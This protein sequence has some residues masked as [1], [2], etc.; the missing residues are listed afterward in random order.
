MPE[1][2]NKNS[3][4]QR[5]I[6][7]RSEK[8]VQIIGIIL[9]VTGGLILLV[10]LEGSEDA[11]L[12]IGIFLAVIGVIIIIR[13]GHKNE[14]QATKELKSQAKSKHVLVLILYFLTVL[15]LCYGLYLGYWMAGESLIGS[16]GLAISLLIVGGG[17][18]E[19]FGTTLWLRDIL[20]N[21]KKK[22]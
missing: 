11:A 13:A 18:D 7:S 20:S 15:A 1:G 16:M 14:R 3:S 21:R 5:V 19:R 22:G 6:S 2:Y 4:T 10:S 8:A 9:L 17:L 12:F